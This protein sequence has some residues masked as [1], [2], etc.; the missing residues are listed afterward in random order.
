MGTIDAVGRTQQNIYTPPI[1]SKKNTEAAVQSWY[2]GWEDANRLE[3]LNSSSQYVT[4]DGKSYHMTAEYAE[5]ATMVF[6]KVKVTVTDE[7]GNVRE[8]QVEVNKVDTGNATAIEMFALCSH[9]DTKRG[10]YK[11][12]SSDTASSWDSL[13]FYRETAVEN[14]DIQ[15]GSLGAVFGTQKYNW[16]DM[17]GKVAETY[18]SDEADTQYLPVDR[19]K[20]LMD[21]YSRFEERPVAFEDWF[22]AIREYESISV[23]SLDSGMNIWIYDKQKKMECYM[24]KETLWSREL[25]DEEYKKAMEIACSPYKA[26]M[27]D[28]SFWDDI[29]S[30]KCQVEEYDSYVKMMKIMNQNEKMFDNCPS[31]VKEAWMYA[32]KTADFYELREKEFI[33]EYMRMQMERMEKGMGANLLGTTVESAVKMAEQMIKKLEEMDMSHMTAEDKRMKLKERVFYCHFLEKLDSAQKYDP[34]MLLLSDNITKKFAV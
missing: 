27:K 9:A 18:S 4:A 10:R 2:E 34:A 21:F 19:M 23:V 16:R 8:Y 7:N 1:T 22:H 6:P 3:K 24:G 5:G 11:D 28:D 29:L 15:P 30:G 33:S 32:E 14:G 13:V 17:V 20:D 25:T 26:Y 12:I 31:K